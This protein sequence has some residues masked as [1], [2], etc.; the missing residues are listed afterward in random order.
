MSC[1]YLHE[2]APDIVQGYGRISKK[3][4]SDPGNDIAKQRSSSQ[5]PVLIARPINTE[6]GIIMDEGTTA[7]RSTH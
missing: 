5:H 2:R 7:I 4:I 6:S 3:S 1:T